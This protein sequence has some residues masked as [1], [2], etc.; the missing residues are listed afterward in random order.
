[1]LSSSKFFIYHYLIINLEKLLIE[2]LINLF[3]FYIY[4]ICI[5]ILYESP[6]YIEMKGVC[7][8]PTLFLFLSLSFTYMSHIQ[9][10]MLQVHSGS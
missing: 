5:H 3:K 2:F 4:Y 10:L 7:G 9:A 1:M 6:L 8:I